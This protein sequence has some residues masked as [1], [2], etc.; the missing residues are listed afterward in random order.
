MFGTTTPFGQPS[1]S[2]SLGSTSVFGQLNTPGAY[3]PFGSPTG[4]SIFGG[5]S[6]RMFG[7][8]SSPIA[9]TTTSGASCTPAF[10][11]SP[12]SF[13]GSSISRQNLAFG[14]I[15]SS[16]NQ[17]N[18]FKN[19]FQQTQ[20]A[21]GSNFFVSSTAFCPSSHSASGEISSPAFGSLL[22]PTFGSTGIA[23]GTSNASAS[24]FGG[25]FGASSTP[26]FGSSCTSMFGTSSTP[27]F[28]A[29]GTPAFGTLSTPGFS[30]SPAPTLTWGFG[31]NV[32]LHTA[33]TPRFGPS[34]A[35]TSTQGSGIWSDLGF[36]PA[37]GPSNSGTRVASYTKTAAVVDGSM[38]PAGKVVS[39]SA[40][41]IYKDKN[42]EELRWKDYQLSDKGGH[43]PVGKSTGGSSV[44]TSITQPKPFSPSPTSCHSSVNPFCPSIPSNPFAPPKPVFL[45]PGSM[46]S[47]NP[48]LSTSG[49]IFSPSIPSNPFAPS[50]PVFSSPGS[51]VSTSPAFSTS[52]NIFS[53]SIP[54][55]PFTPPKLV[56]SSPGFTVST[57]PLLTTGNVFSQSIPSNPFA[58]PKPVFSSPGF[59][60]SPSPVSSTG[61]V[62]SPS[63][64][65]NPF[66]PQ[67]PTFSFPISGVSTTPAFNPSPFNTLSSVNP[68]RAASL[69][70]LST[71]VT[72]SALA[73][74]PNTSPSPFCP[75]TGSSPLY[76]Y[77]SSSLGQTNALIEPTTAT[78]CSQPN[79]FNT[80]SLV[81]PSNLAAFGHTTASSS[82][83]LQP[84]ETA[85]TSAGLDSFVA[86]TGI[87]ERTDGE[88]PASQST[89]TVQPAAV[90]SP[91]GTEPTLPEVSVG[92]PGLAPSLQY[93]ISSIPVLDKPASVRTKSLLIIRTRRSRLAAQKF[94]PRS[95][96]PK[97]P[98]F[99]SDEETF[100]TSRGN[101]LLVPR[102][103]PRA[104]ILRSSEQWLL[105][106]NAEQLPTLN[107]QSYHVY[108]NGNIGDNG[109]GEAGVILAKLNLKPN[110]MR[111][112][113]STKKEGSCIEIP[114]CRDGQNAGIHQ[115]EANVEPIV[116]KLRH[117]DY[118]TEPQIQELAAKERAEP[119]FCR[120]VKEFVVGRRGYGSIKFLGE[121]DVRQL[122]IESHVQFN[123]R[124]VIVHMDESK[125]PPVGQGLNKPAEVTLLN[126][127]C[128]DKKTGKHYID[129]PKVDKYRQMLIK[130]V[131]E[132]GGE[133]VAYDPVEGEWKFRVQH[134]S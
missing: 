52:G 56:F 15:G 29:S 26:A 47:N 128:I 54:S 32:A 91:C 2:S 57:S 38:Q 114:G 13:S 134:F 24:G 39:I 88:Q 102:E 83:P 43:K 48:V 36:F 84:A 72:S 21:F 78:L 120:R 71:H 64:T 107:H 53:P 12:S 77:D 62:F 109:K 67:P 101:A 14:G 100:S 126:I 6:T 31:T 25:A 30:T 105:R 96:G 7:V 129:G 27:V 130:K 117:S 89:A 4:E 23:F 18:S 76:P 40:M 108:E 17:S 86:V 66:T 97:V 95:N 133:F 103:N 104:F 34:P 110:G 10:G 79:M 123:N 92:H 60:V 3:A 122:D 46:L 113:H 75:S 8:T 28:G 59:T 132:Q 94:D 22:I 73:S 98:F 106:A 87:G 5:N 115:H 112:D 50:K 16:S 121:T 55:N 74:A 42:H 65:S 116:P 70:K 44:L 49:N 20:P 9:S 85:K 1:S 41:P 99:S 37:F 111:D 93:G 80:P 19:A 35:T 63:T 11:S 33:S 90:T 68:L 127:K 51:T 58:P 119:G 125:K 131:A 61:N 118:Y 81:S 124:E 69:S 45:S 82:T